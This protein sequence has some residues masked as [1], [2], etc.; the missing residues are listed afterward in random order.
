MRFTLL[1]VLLVAASGSAPGQAGN[2]ADSGQT[3]ETPARR[4][5]SREG[6][7]A[8]LLAAIVPVSASRDWAAAQAAFPG[9]RWEA[10][11]SNT[12]PTVV[13]D[14]I[15]YPSQLESLG[16]TDALDGSI[17]L[18]GDRFRITIIGTPERVTG[19]RLFA[20]EGTLISRTTLSRALAAHGVGWRMLRC[21]PIGDTNVPII[22]ELTAGGQSMIG[23]DTFSGNASVYDFYFEGV[24]Y[25]PM[26][27]PGDCT[28]AGLGDLR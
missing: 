9:A 27:P 18:N 1:A 25:D 11:R 7:V 23:E 4:S 17:D 19:I 13:K 2:L 28:G 10:R 14:G 12:V 16:Y 26:D 8:Q 21:N 20:P 5:G 6:Q 15:T 24:P 3:V 22:V